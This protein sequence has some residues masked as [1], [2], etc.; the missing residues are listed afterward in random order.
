MPA[1]L[2]GARLSVCVFVCL[3]VCVQSMAY[4][5]VTMTLARK[6]GP[7]FFMLMKVSRCMRSFSASSSSVWIHLV[8]SRQ[9]RTSLVGRRVHT[10]REREGEKQHGSG[11]IQSELEVQ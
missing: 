2:K 11:A 1:S 10:Q 3:C 6:K 9:C 7:G 4:P 5:C 8:T